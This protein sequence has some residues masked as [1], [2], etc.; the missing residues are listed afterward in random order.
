MHSHGRAGD[1][2]QQGAHHDG[3][4][5]LQLGPG[6]DRAGPQVRFHRLAH[7][8]FDPFTLLGLGGGHP[9]AMRL[10]IVSE[11]TPVALEW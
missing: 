8:P 10:L 4:L 6:E 1:Q 11:I 9:N 2:G 3:G 7:Q 5:E